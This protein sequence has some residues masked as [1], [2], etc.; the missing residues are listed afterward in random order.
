MAEILSLLSLA[1]NISPLEL[2][3][4]WLFKSVSNHPLPD[5]CVDKMANKR[6]GLH[7]HSA[8][9]VH[10]TEHEKILYETQILFKNNKHSVLLTCKK[11]WVLGK[12]RREVE[13]DWLRNP[14]KASQWLWSLQI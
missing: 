7:A 9:L 6:T 8:L 3:L 5:L 4:I 11:F 13:S 10:K 1:E 12:S 14:D 2:A